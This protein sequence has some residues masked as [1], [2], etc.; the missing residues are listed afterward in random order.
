MRDNTSRVYRFQTNV[1][2][3]R[4]VGLETFAELDVLRWLQG[5]AARSSLTWFSNFTVLHTEY[6]DAPSDI[7]G[8]RVEFS[9]A[10]NLRSGVSWK[11]ERLGVSAQVSYLSQQYTDATNAPN[12]PPVPGA[13]EGAIPAYYVADLTA[14]YVINDWL[15]AEGSINNLT[16]NMYFTRRATGYPGPGIIPS[17][18]RTFYIT[19]SGKF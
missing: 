13:V 18:G 7:E 5:A 15:K 10:I 2:D 14:S 16:D 1:G 4:N 17:D 19:I 12:D 9:P 11:W 3:A 8:N 6:V